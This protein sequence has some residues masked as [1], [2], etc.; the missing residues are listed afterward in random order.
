MS[1]P[2]AVGVGFGAVDDAT[3]AGAAVA[4]PAGSLLRM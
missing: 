1:T 4:A 3:T 2:G